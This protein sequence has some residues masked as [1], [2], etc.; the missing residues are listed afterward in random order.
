VARAGA[1]GCAIVPTLAM[2][3]GIVAEVSRPGSPG[4][5]Y[6]AARA[7]VAA[8]H[9]AGVPV[10]AG[11]DANNAAGV[12]FSPS[13]GESLPHDWNCRPVRACPPWRHCARPPC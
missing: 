9:R 2:M 10:L 12:P 6:E 3:E 5:S 13:F 8:L 11:I 7:S 4:P 1:D